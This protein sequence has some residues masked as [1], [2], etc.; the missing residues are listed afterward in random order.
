MTCTAMKTK[1]KKIIGISAALGLLVLL[2]A[3]GMSA[4]QTP[5]VEALPEPP[6]AVSV[7]RP[8]TDTVF[9]VARYLGVVEGEDDAPLSFRVS[10]TIA[11]LYIQEGQRV[12]AGQLLAELALPESAARLERARMELA[13]AEA[14]LLY[15]ERERGI[16]QRLYE[17]GA[18]PRSKLDQTQLAYEQA[19]RGRG[20]ARAGVEEAAGL[21]G[22]AQLRAP[23]AG[24]VGRIDRATGE[25][26][27]PGQPVLLLNAGARR[28]RADVLE[29]DRGRGIRQGSPARL[30]TPT[31]RDVPGEIVRVDAA[32][33]AP[34]QSV[35]VY[36]TFPEACLAGLPAGAEVPVTFLLQPE[37]GATLVPISAVDLRGGAP[38]V[39]R[40][41]P[42][43]TAEA[44]PV[45]LG[46][47]Q[48]EWQQVRGALS[49]EDRVVIS[50]T[51]NLQPGARVQVAEELDSLD[52]PR[53]GIS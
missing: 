13:K 26:V 28:V 37:V 31:C 44:V 5:E 22:A 6:V 43:Q 49:P 29:R 10:G 52:L 2:G 11:R 46:L 38:R 18:I 19:L 25:T 20:A 16:D 27:M 47:Q 14:N 9:H 32:V 1:K 3:L 34:L 51:T 40:I 53:G 17:K 36:T 21:A 33:R 12:A 50:G 23:R 41:G 45:A 4:R 15:L 30:T 39:F 8:A 48:G 7:T 42:G 35:R 24:V